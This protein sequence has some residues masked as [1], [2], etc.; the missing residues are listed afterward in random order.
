MKA[1][2]IN[3]ETAFLHGNLDEEMHMDA[4]LGLEIEPNK[5]LI[6][7]KALK[8]IGFKGSKI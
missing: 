1:T 2:I 4:S 8:I 3:F 6:L 5:R 7:C